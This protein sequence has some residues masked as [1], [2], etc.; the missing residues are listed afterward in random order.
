MAGYIDIDEQRGFSLGSIP[1]MNIVDLTR[2][3]FKP[4]EEKYIEEIYDIYDNGGQDIISLEEQN[5]EG[6]NIFFKATNTSYQTYKQKFEHGSLKSEFAKITLD[7][8]QEFI[9]IL[10]NDKRYYKG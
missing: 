7:C 1:F 10:R 8:W 5:S 4:N 9:D 6:F 2:E 3:S